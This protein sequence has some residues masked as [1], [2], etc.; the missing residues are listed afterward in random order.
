MTGR[1]FTII[2]LT[3]AVAVLLSSCVNMPSSAAGA[4][5][6]TGEMVSRDFQ[7][8]D[9]TSIDISGSFTVIY[10]QDQN[11]SVVVDM[12]ENLFQHLQVLVRGGTLYIDSARQFNTS[13]ANR[14]RLYINAPALEAIRFSGAI[15]AAEWDAISIQ[16]FSVSVEGAA[17]IALALEADQLDVSVAGASNIE[18]SGNAAAAGISIEG[19]GRVSADNLQTRDANVSISGAGGV[20][21]AV[22]DNLDVSIDGAGS[23]RYIGSPNVTRSIAGIGTVRHN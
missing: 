7:T 3:A 19:A 10:R 23:V 22:S 5:Q 16:S 11:I 8:E 14:P 13:N 4:V 6:G 1:I 15:D 21:I 9:F 18:L 12:Q 20:I 2:S 17:N